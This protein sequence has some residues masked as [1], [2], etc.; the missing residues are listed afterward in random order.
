MSGIKLNK[1]KIRHIRVRKK[2][3]LHGVSVNIYPNLNYFDN[4]VACGL[5]NS[6]ATSINDLGL[7]VTFSDFD[8]VLRYNF[9]KLL[10]NIWFI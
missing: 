2:I 1:R 6:K 8:K 4:I 5:E 7:D 10:K 9:E 3:A